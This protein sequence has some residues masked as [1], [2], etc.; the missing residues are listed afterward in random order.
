MPLP[1]IGNNKSGFSALPGGARSLGNYFGIGKT[2]RWW[3]ST[4][5]S[6]D[7]CQ[8][9]VPDEISINQNTFIMYFSTDVTQ[10]NSV[11]CVKD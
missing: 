8:C 2:A 5:S 9:G 3:L 10:G 4:E 6:D 11:R 1:G 7:G